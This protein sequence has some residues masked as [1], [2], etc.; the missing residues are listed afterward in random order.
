MIPLF[1]ILLAVAAVTAQDA[2]E[3]STDANATVKPSADA[4]AVGFFLR[5]KVF[6]QSTVVKNFNARVDAWQ[7]QLDAANKAG[8][9]ATAKAIHEKYD[10]A[11]ASLKSDFTKV[12]EKVLPKICREKGVAVAF[13][14]QGEV[15]WKNREV[16]TVD[17][18]EDLLAAIAKEVPEKKP[19]PAATRTDSDSGEDDPKEDEQPETDG[20]GRPVDIN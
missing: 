2:T 14:G 19:A 18:T 4:M 8:D 13:N 6:N 12:L 11:S 17:L 5:A 10:K 7:A 1:T 20:W 9:R 16:R 15:A 3:S